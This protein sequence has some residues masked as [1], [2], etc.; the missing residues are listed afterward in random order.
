MKANAR[1][2]GTPSGD[3]Y[4]RAD[5]KLARGDMSCRARKPLKLA[6]ESRKIVEDICL[7]VVSCQLSVVGCRQL[8]TDNREPLT[9]PSQRLFQQ[10]VALL[11]LILFLAAH[12]LIGAAEVADDR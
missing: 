1:P 7:C 6:G 11:L 10:L 4:I 2:I 12:Q 3:R 8:I 9:Q 5:S